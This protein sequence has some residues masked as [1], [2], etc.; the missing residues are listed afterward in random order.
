MKKYI[1]SALLACLC[2]LSNLFPARLME[3]RAT[4][5]AP[6][7]GSYA[8]IL[9][10]DAFFYATRDERTGLFLLPQTYYVKILEYANDF[11]KVEYLYDAADAK[12]LVGYAKTPT[13]TPVDYTPKTPYLY[14][15]FTVTYLPQ[16]ESA[17]DAPFLDKITVDCTYY[18]DYIVGS[19]TYC[20]ALRDGQFGYIPK[21]DD[22]TFPRNLEYEEYLSAPD[23][24]T[25]DT[26]S[27]SDEKGSSAAQIAIL[28][29][30]C[31]LVP[32]LAAL[33]LKPNRRPPYDE[34]S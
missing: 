31:L 17:G 15:R 23:E 8:C 30:V 27:S 12:K 21:P 34:E 6:E 5:A 33:I 22:L 4:A 11:C 29:A 19:K 32:V 3:K 9:S 7:T 13:L 25:Q 14:K 28:I 2:F 26:R 20:Y 10:A 18:G 16:S 1:L 24:P